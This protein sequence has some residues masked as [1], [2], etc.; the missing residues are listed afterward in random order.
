MAWH[1]LAVGYVSPAASAAIVQ[2]GGRIIHI[3]YNPAFEMVGLW[4]DPA[5]YW[6]WRHGRNEHL[7]GI[8]FWNTGYIQMEHLTLQYGPRNA[9]YQSIEET[10]LVMPDEVVGAVG[11]SSD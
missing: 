9:E 10:H 11:F 2:Q 7:N 5:G 1:W 6:S 8:E 3:N 4:H